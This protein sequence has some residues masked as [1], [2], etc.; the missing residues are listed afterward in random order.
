MQ[1]TFP[2]FCGMDIEKIKVEL[3]VRTKDIE[4]T[5]VAHNPD[6][7]EAIASKLG[8]VSGKAEEG[9]KLIAD[10]LNSI[11]IEE[12]VEFET[13]VEKQKFLELIK[14]TFGIILKEKLNQSF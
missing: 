12:G 4:L 3:V 5:K 14:P 13:E 2:Y 8:S 9:T 10:V 1:L 11:L 7:V 6:P